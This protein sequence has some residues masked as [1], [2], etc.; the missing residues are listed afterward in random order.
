MTTDEILDL[1]RESGALLEGALHP[2]VRPALAGLPAEGQGVHASGQGGKAVP[3]AGGQDPS[4]RLCRRQPD[5]LPGGRR[6]HSGLRD[7]AAPR[8]LPAIYTER[9]DGQFEARRGFRGC[10]RARRCWWSRISSRRGCRSAS[11][12]RRSARP[13]RTW[14][15]RPALID[16][17]GGEADIGVPL[18]SLTRY[19]VPAYPADATAGTGGNS[20]DQAGKPGAGV[21]VAAPFLPSPL[22]GE[23]ALRSRAGEG[24]SLLAPLGPRNLR[25]R[26]PSSGAARRS[27]PLKGRREGAW[28]K[29]RGDGP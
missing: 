20:S 28:G 17:S 21:M 27:L 3:G 9:V 22:E 11:A 18:V 24:Q 4:G 14:W 5:R 26:Y 2:F 6:H 19:K 13:A 7:G 29:D 12:S 10:S 15:P 8:R 16:R 23:G 1:F 25:L